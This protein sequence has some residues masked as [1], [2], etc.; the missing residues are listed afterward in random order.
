MRAFQS[1]QIT[2]FFPAGMQLKVSSMKLRAV[3]SSIP[4]FYIFCTG[5]KYTLPVHIFSPPGTCM[6]IPYA[7]S[8]PVYLNIFM[9]FLTIIAIPPLWPLLLR[10]SNT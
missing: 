5:G 3:S 10:C 9:P 7:Y 8:L 6:H 4:R 1:P 2:A